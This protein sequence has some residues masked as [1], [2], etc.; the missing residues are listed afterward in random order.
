MKISDVVCVACGSSYLVAESASA[1]AS[2]G[3]ANCAVC[4]HLLASWQEPR[5]RAYRLEMSPELRYAR[6]QP[7]PSPQ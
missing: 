4:G 6:V 1:Y 3:D 5:M 7:P 2:P